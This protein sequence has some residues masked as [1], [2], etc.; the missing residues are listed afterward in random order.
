MSTTF[1][2]IRKNRQSWRDWT[3]HSPAVAGGTLLLLIVVGCATVSWWSPYSSEKSNMSE[4][5]LVPSWRHPMG[6]DGLGRDLLT[7]V[8]YGGRI[9]LV[10]GV[11]A[12]ALGLSL[13]TG[14]GSLSGLQAGQVDNLVMRV[15]DVFLALPRIVILILMTVYLRQIDLPLLQRG[16]GVVGIVLILGLL[17]WMGV[18]RQVRAQL[19][20]LKEWDFVL[21][22]QAVGVSPTGVL[23]RHL[24]PN[25]W[26][27]VIVAASLRIAGAVMAESGLSFLGFGVQP[28]TPTWG[29]ILTNGQ[30]ELLKG[31]FWLVI[32]PGLMIFITVISINF[33]GDGLRD[34]LDPRR[35]MGRK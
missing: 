21:A 14:L 4:R 25:A 29:N 3:A 2:V 26:T 31:H 6:T 12:T 20:V 22:A 30:D 5:Y 34:A 17:S 33:L 19:L 24:L 1:A 7:R 18:A 28:P 23:W 27:P 32:F 35:A 8:L 15:A 9:S 16:G 10:V 11:L 13:G